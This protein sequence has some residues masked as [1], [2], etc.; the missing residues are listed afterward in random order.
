[1]KNLMLFIVFVCI[2]VVGYALILP[3]FTDGSTIL[4]SWIYA[5]RLE[6]FILYAMTTLFI[7]VALA[8]TAVNFIFAL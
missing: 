3:M 2:M 4:P 5:Y 8:F 7:G 1:M 6:F